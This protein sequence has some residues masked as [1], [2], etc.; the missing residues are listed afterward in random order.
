M[1]LPGTVIARKLLT[2]KL[3]V[4]LGS[5]EK[6]EKNVACLM[7]QWVKIR[8]NLHVLESESDFLLRVRIRYAITFYEGIINTTIHLD[9]LKTVLQHFQDLVH[10]DAN[11]NLIDN[12]LYNRMKMD[13][14]YRE[15]LR[16]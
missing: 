12:A 8:D 13:L 16:S 6:T 4:S 10:L 2:D 1:S 7:D 9:V 11:D 3:E 5:W 14:K 15:L